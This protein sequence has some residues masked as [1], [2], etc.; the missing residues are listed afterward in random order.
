MILSGAESTK[1]MKD[2]KRMEGG[3]ER[4][5]MWMLGVSRRESEGFEPGW[6]GAGAGSGAGAG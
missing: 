2:D 6:T 1:G 4:C 3:V 5:W